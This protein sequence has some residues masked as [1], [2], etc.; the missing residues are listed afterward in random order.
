MSM[1]EKVQIGV[2]LK[3]VRHTFI[4]I[5]VPTTTRN[6]MQE[7]IH[8]NYTFSPNLSSMTTKRVKFQSVMYVYLY[9]TVTSHEFNHHFC[10]GLKKF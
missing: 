10:S 3:I 4:D 2:A 8:F 1:L 7:V 9:L 6:F 5:F